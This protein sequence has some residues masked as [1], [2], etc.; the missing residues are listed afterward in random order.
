MK[1]D[2]IDDILNTIQASLPPGL[3]AMGQDLRSHIELKL[4]E[5]FEA[6]GLV[7]Q[8]HFDI[9]RQVLLRTREKL[10]ALEKRVSELEQNA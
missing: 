9:Q 2:L 10:E 8:E 1:P 4:K 7:T 3:G 6:Q 5:L